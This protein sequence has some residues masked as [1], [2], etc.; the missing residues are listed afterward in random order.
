MMY[1]YSYEARI[2]LLIG[3]GGVHEGKYLYLNWDQYQGLDLGCAIYHVK[4]LFI[5]VL[6][7]TTGPLGATT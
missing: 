4:M 6:H 2:G 5:V 1:M 7:V 3:Y